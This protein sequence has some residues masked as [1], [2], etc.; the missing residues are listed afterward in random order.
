MFEDP[1]R[2][3][4]SFMRLPEFGTTHQLL[5]KYSPSA[6]VVYDMA[7]FYAT[8]NGRTCGTAEQPNHIDDYYELDVDYIAKMAWVTPDEVVSIIKENFDND[9]DL[10]EVSK[11]EG[12]KYFIKEV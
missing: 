5:S 2:K 12:K 9:F 8:E 3:G 10:L 6:L 4:L 11:S 7:Y 1:C